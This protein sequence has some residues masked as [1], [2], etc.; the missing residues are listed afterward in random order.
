VRRRAIAWCIVALC[1]LSALPAAA[2]GVVVVHARGADE[3]AA[4]RLVTMISGAEDAVTEAVPT[5]MDALIELAAIGDAELTVVLDG[6][7]GE[8]H[9]VRPRDRTIVSRSVGRALYDGSAHAI[10]VAATELVGLAR[11]APAETAATVPSAADS[12]RDERG[13]GA[14]WLSP[15]IEVAAGASG[16]LGPGPTSFGVGLAAGGTLAL[17]AS[18]WAPSLAVTGTLHAEHAVSAPGADPAQGEARYRRIDLALRA[19]LAHRA[20]DVEL[21]GSAF[22]GLDL[23]S[24]RLVDEGGA[25]RGTHDAADVWLGVGLGVRRTLGV[26]LSLGLSLAVDWATR[27]TRYLVSGSPVV[28]EGRVRA[29]SALELAW[30]PRTDP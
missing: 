21:I 27:P 8:I 7:R 4:R 19:S 3:A 26:G 16:G 20:T 30:S 25:V 29:R 1:V 18:P 17:P 23:S 24:A 2:Q 15:L 6:S 13:H 22:A 14:P 11:E 5:G 12:D 10:A 9:V 28:S